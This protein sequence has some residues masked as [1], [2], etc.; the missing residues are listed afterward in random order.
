MRGFALAVVIGAIG[1]LMVTSV[2]WGSWVAGGSDS[3]C[4][5]HQA[6]RWAD[7][8][9]QLV[10][11]RLAGL[12][13]AEPLAL[14]AP[15]PDAARAFAPSGH[16][17]SPTVAGA[18]VPI[19]PAGLSIAMAPFVLAGGPRAAFYVLPL[20]AAMLVAATSVVGSRFGARVGLLSSLLVAAS[21]IVL[22]Q[23]IQ[24]M[25]DV[26]AAALWMLAVALATGAAPRSSLLSGLATSAAILV[27]PNLVPLGFTIGLFLLLRPERNWPQRLR[28][29]TTYAL[30]CAP[31]CVVVALT[32]N[33]L[34]GSPFASGY[35]SL[36]ALFSPSSVTANLGRYLGWLWSAHTAAITLALLAPWLL[37]GGLTVLAL[38]MFFVN[39]ALYVPYVIFDDW[40]YLRFLLPTIPLL[41]ILVVAVLDGALRRIRVPGGAWITAAAV[42][43]LSVLFVRQAR[44][45]PTFV[46]KQLEARFERA[47]VFVGRRLPPNALVI[48]SAESGSVRF[49][50]GRK[51]LIW[52]GLDPAWLDRALMY[53][54]SKGYEPYLLFERREET[55]FRQRFAGSA[56]GRLDWPPMA[57]V[58]AQVRIYRPEDRERYLRGTLPPTE[59]AP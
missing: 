1:V 59:F 48:T 41:L 23:V 19:C 45:R 33:A 42:V 58:G 8:F 49:Y 44:E 37:P 30:A 38:V 25:S 21:P 29:A 34:Y 53:V 22:Y 28:S 57:E 15:W 46:L 35:G 4:Y 13:V 36:A 50:A 54:R 17:P 3:Y 16:L 6:E 7:V 9:S 10:R 47:G 52:D 14:D 5:V 2:R 51:T 12:Q 27:R 32:Q 11:G 26:P 39:L 43:V 55:D 20:F 24:P 56:I 40:S 18:I 31:G